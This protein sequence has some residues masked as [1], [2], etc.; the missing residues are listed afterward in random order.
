MSQ[1]L[2]VNLNS[3]A[4]IREE[5]DATLQRAA[6]EF[7]AWLLD[8]QNRGAIENCA[9]DIGQI[10]GTLRLIQFEAAALLADE[11]AVTVRAMAGA[12][13][14]AGAPA[15]EALAGTLSHA[16]FLLPRFVEFVAGRQSV[17]PILIIA[18]VN[19]LRVARRQPLVPEYHFEQRLLPL[20][21]TITLPGA[22]T[23]NR[24]VLERLRQMYQVGLLAILRQQNRASNLQLLARASARFADLAPAASGAGF[25]HLAA[26]ATDCLAREALALDLNR[27]RT[28]GLVERMMARYLKG[29]EEAL[30]AALDDGVRRELVHMLA[31]SPYRE[32][33]VR[34]VID[35]FDIPALRPDDRELGVLREALRGPGLEAI[36]SVVRVLK[37]ELRNAKDILE[38]AAQNQGIAAEE[39]TP[40]RDTLIRVADT[41]RVV[42]LRAPGEVLREQLRFVDTWAEHK[43]GVP[44]EQFLAVADAVLFIESSLAGLYR[45]EINSNDL[46]QITDSARKQIVADNQLAEAARIVIEE[47][48]AAIALAKRAITAYVE[49]DFDTI[50]IANVAV[51]LNTVR[52]GMYIL[53]HGRAAAILQGC[54]AFVE[55]HCRGQ[56]QNTPRQQLLE[57][58]ADALISLE[59]YLTELAARRTPDRK[60]L[61]VAQESL[62]ALG[63]AVEF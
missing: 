25:W 1:E 22:D 41:L 63:F 59:Y 13:P 61:D 44:P 51:T 49:S 32:G 26:A 15:A 57:T 20:T 27:R 2:A 39:L 23:P 40:L 9:A 8:N 10:A 36:D 31:L 60:I 7:E 58:L 43:N 38:I 56:T 14:G 21:P 47:A 5:L 19:E 16:F 46:E 18:Y 24:A 4:L 62:A 54:I 28:L 30:A 45:H 50:H 35:A 53:E 6:G 37:E 17:P 55:N 33:R 29:G 52:G 42:N 48:Q 34:T 12:E 11:M 3:L